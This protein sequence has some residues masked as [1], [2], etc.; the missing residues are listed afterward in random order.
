MVDVKVRLDVLDVEEG[1]ADVV[2][3]EIV[4][5]KDDEEDGDVEVVVAAA[6]V[7]VVVL[8]VVG[9]TWRTVVVKVRGA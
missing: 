6:V 2:R 4:T 3:E 9:A 5:A 1:V 8:V 7:V